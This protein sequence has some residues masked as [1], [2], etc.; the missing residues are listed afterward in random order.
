MLTAQSLGDNI[1]SLALL[2]CTF[3]V[4]LVVSFAGVIALHL[5][6]AGLRAV[7]DLPVRPA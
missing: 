6:L 4:I 1:Y 5:K 3:A 2:M 7:L